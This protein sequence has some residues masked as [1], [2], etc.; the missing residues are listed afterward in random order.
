VSAESVMD[1]HTP[2][3]PAAVFSPA[4]EQGIGR[5]GRIQTQS[6]KHKKTINKKVLPETRS[7]SARIEHFGT[8]SIRWWSSLLSTSD[9]ISPLLSIFSH[10]SKHFRLSWARAQESLQRLP[11]QL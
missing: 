11:N 9:A 2:L 10:F 4:S 8:P 6:N 1:L 3:H 5:A 7:K